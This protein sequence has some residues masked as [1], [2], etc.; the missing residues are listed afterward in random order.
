MTVKEI[1]KL[2]NTSIGTVDR[3]LHNRGRVLPETEERIREIIKKHQFTPNPIARR[4]KRNK[5][6]KFCAIVPQREQDSGY[7]G[8]IISGIQGGAGE[9]A[10]LGIETSIIEF[11]HYDSAA[12]RAAARETLAK[13]PDG[14]IF[15]P[16][17]PEIA[18]PFTVELQKKQIPY[19]FF[20]ADLPNAR[21]ICTIGQDPF[22]GGFLAGKLLHLFM[23]KSKRTVAVFY[24]PKSYHISRRKD[25]FLHYCREHG[26]TAVAKNYSRKDGMVLSDREISGFMKKNS[27]LQGI[28]VS[29]SDVHQIARAVESQ[30][31]RGFFVVGYDLV[32]ENHKLLAEGR[33]DAIISQR[34]QEQSHQAL[35][36]LYRSIVLENTIDPTIEIP[37]DIYIR[38]NV[39]D[40]PLVNGKPLL[41]G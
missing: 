20:D 28:F 22:Q 13:E 12:F 23:G 24:D 16:I 25:G 2:A 14:V 41:N 34:P 36:S 8:E 27:G 19:V 4:L 7:W 10:S 38:E 21:P 30:R 29:Y 6:Y 40:L 32:P 18:R 1:A 37:L 35:L 15:A 39:P 17:F 33:I 3:V 5:A 26:I 11:D 9:I 31:R